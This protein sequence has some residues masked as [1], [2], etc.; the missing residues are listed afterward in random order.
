MYCDACI[1]IKLLTNEPDSQRWSDLL[2]GHPLACSELALTEV[3][4]ALLAKQRDR[5][6]SARD[7]ARAWDQLER[8]VAANELSLYPLVAAT[9]S[10]ARNILLACHPKEPL[11]TLDAL[12]LAACDLSQDFP[13][14]S[15][16]ARV[17]AAA[18]H[19]GIPVAPDW[20]H[21]AAGS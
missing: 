7:R 4:A 10:K 11:R 14:A 1:L 13:L 17:R 2:E 18:R 9:H 16:D 5:R 3:F 12:H 21:D 8:W 15:S 19:L 6:L 20:P